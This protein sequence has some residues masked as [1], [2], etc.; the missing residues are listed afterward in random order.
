[1]SPQRPFEP[2]VDCTG[3]G[4]CIDTV[5]VP[6]TGTY[7]VRDGEVLRAPEVYRETD[8]DMGRRR[9]T[10]WVEEKTDD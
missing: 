1:V 9:Y 3:C 4:D 10:V 5:G 8:T 2:D 7:L 6:V